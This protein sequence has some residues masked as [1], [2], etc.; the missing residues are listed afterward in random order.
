MTGGWLAVSSKFWPQTIMLG[1]LGGLFM[2]FPPS[3]FPPKL[4]LIFCGLILMLA[5][6]A[7]LPA[8][9]FGSSIRESFR[10]HGIDL[11]STLSAQPWLS[12][13]DLTLLIAT[14]LWAWFCFEADLSAGQ[15]RF[16][17]SAYLIG[18]LILA[19]NTILQ[20]TSLAACVPS[21]LIGAGQFENR[22]QTGDLLLMSGIV[23]ASRGFSE[24]SRGK[25]GGVLWILATGL[26]MTAI[27][28][29][30]SRTAVVL[31]GVGL[32]LLWVLRP[33]FQRHGWLIKLM[34]M[35]V[36][37][38]SIVMLVLMNVELRDRFL[39][40]IEKG[41]E[42]RGPI[43]H[44]TLALIG[45]SPWCGIGLGNFEGYFNV[46][47]DSSAYLAERC[48]HPDSDWL[49]LA[50]ELGVGGVVL[51]GI[52]IVLIFRIYLVK[53]PFRNLTHTSLTVALLFL[54]HSL[55]DVGGHRLGTVWSCLYLPSLGAYRPVPSPE[56]GFPSI[57]GRLAGIFLLMVAIF[58]IQSVNLEPWMP[59]RGSLTYLEK[60]RPSDMSLSEQHHL[61]TRALV[62]APLQWLP[63]YQRGLIRL[64][65][66]AM[67][68]GA[69]ADFDRALYLEQNSTGLPLSIGDA[70]RSSD[71][72]ESLVAWNELLRRS[73]ERR[74]EFL[75]NIYGA[76]DLTAKLRL[77]MVSL[78]GDDPNLQI[79]AIASQNPEDFGWLCE[80]FLTENTSLEGVKPALAKRLFD[81]WVDMG[82]P[83]AFIDQWPQHPEWRAAGWSAY[84]RALAK[85]GRYPEAVTTVL[86]NMSAPDLSKIYSLD[87]AEANRQSAANPGDPFYLVQLY[88]AETAA[89]ANEDAL[90][91]LKKADAL[92]NRPSYVPYLLAKA[93]H[94]SHEDEAAWEALKPL[95]NP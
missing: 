4:I 25:W 1:A 54:F 80:N 31:F 81:R 49:W 16:F 74:E 2:V 24:L 39:V 78:A 52:L 50:S 12:L 3:R 75:Q 43:Y 89:G 10:G 6:T 48:L 14:F 45:S 53:T 55:F 91:T 66:P 23:S 56:S 85:A 17:I 11:P 47:R 20:A 82:D 63:Y 9:W 35:I 93:L 26:F 34:G 73:P 68:D 79:I 95:L 59:T 71:P 36:I 94:D 90:A 29:N 72:A 41:Q 18:T 46:Q 32:L 44:D 51:F 30:G 40:F 77:E 28:L 19:T 57:A 64:Q 69:N 70:C 37:L 86:Q 87:L 7:F 15:R 13:E 92:S 21:F 65:S 38:F 76:P 60:S 5:F 8:N 33:E 58:R 42:G 62:W 83:A 84:A 88:L 61:L 27:L 67:M 22:N